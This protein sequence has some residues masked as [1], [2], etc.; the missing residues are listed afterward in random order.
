M[1]QVCSENELFMK[2]SSTNVNT[3]RSLLKGRE[4]CITMV[5]IKINHSTIR[6]I[7]NIENLPVVAKIV[8]KDNADEVKWKMRGIWNSTL[9]CNNLNYNKIIITD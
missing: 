8:K 9:K 5:R 7:E 6:M 1:F 4:N 3:F 2:C